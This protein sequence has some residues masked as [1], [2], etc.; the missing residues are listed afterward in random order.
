MVR[1]AQSG[2]TLIEII[3]VLA[4]SS[5][6]F[7]AVLAGE[8]YLRSRT[9]FDANVNRVVAS[10]TEA[11]NRAAS[12]RNT[13]G[14]GT[15][16]AKCGGAAPNASGVFPYREYIFAGT[17]WVASGT[18]PMITI[19]S[20]KALPG[21]FACSFDSEVVAIPSNTVASAPAPNGGR[22]L[23]I[24]DDFGRVRTCFLTDV[25]TDVSA[26]FAGGACPTNLTGLTVSVADNESHTADVV[27]DASGLARRN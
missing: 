5:L 2:F 19:R 4:L 25:T 15:G 21:S 17:E 23:F 6:M 24:R 3:F 14:D 16:T 1:R 27:I 20:W 7:V 11:R 12:V 18:S 8:R 22:V 10:E 9:Q 13:A 26:T